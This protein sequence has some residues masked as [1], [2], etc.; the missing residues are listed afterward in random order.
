[1][2]IFK[3]RK[4]GDEIEFQIARKQLTSVFAH[5]I[6]SVPILEAKLARRCVLSGNTKIKRKVVPLYDFEVKFV[7]HESIFTPKSSNLKDLIRFILYFVFE[8]RR[9]NYTFSPIL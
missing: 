9:V 4:I 2:I 5:R 1:M 3:Y 8:I 6:L 7:C